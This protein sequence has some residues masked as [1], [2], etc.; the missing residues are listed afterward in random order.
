MGRHP[1]LGRV[2]QGGGLVAR[3]RTIKPDAFLSESL[4]QVDF[5][6]R[7]TFAGI[8]TYLDDHGY[9]RGD[10]RLIRAALFPLDDGVTVGKVTTA[11]ESLVEI[12]S[13]CIYEVEGKRYIHSPNWQDHQRVNRPTA[14]KLPH[15]PDHD[16]TDRGMTHAR[17]TESSVRAH[18]GLTGGRERKGKEKEP[19]SAAADGAFDA[20]WAKYP[21]KVSKA[22]AQRAWAKA[23]KGGTAPD[24][25]TNGLLA[26]LGNWANSDPKFIPHA[27]TWLSGERWN[28]SAAIDLPTAS[29]SRN[30]ARLPKCPT[31]NAPQE[32]IHYDDCTDQEWRP[33]A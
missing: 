31:C 20:F 18:G 10:A 29:E 5:F 11:I 15:C 19:S 1:L 8:W 9:G 21:R 23:T 3:I 16:G 26:Q 2:G 30:I 28:D 27:S 13:L 33:T 7:W 14:S 25:I 22:D 32:V 17:L 4:S 12:G 24:V 6:T